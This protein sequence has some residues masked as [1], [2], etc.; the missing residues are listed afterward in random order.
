MGILMTFLDEFSN[1]G[2]EPGEKLFSSQDWGRL[3]KLVGFSD[4]E[5]QVCRLIFEGKTRKETGIAL[6]IAT[7]TVRHYMEILYQKLSVTNRVA[8]VLRLVQLRDHLNQKEQ[9]GKQ[10]HQTTAQTSDGGADGSG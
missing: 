2:G 5:Y 6:G 8:M 4:R 9:L 3:R 10:T 7:R 1:L